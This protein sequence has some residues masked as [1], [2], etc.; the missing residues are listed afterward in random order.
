MIPAVPKNPG[1]KETCRL[2]RQDP[3]GSETPQE[4]GAKIQYRQQRYESV[5]VT[6]WVPEIIQRQHSLT[7]AQG[8]SMGSSQ[9][10]RDR[11]PLWGWAPGEADW[12]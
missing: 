11:G 4:A 3:G 7:T 6:E 10:D 12:E 9:H 5:A 8:D 1:C 2:Q